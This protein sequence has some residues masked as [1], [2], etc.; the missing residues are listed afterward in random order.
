MLIEIALRFLH[1]IACVMILLEVSEIRYKKTN[2]HE[3]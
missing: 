1:F 3:L 2:V